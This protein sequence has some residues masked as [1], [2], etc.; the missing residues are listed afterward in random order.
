MR[1]VSATGAEPK[2]SKQELH[3][4]VFACTECY[5]DTIQIFGLGTNCEYRT[6]SQHDNLI[7]NRLCESGS[8]TGATLVAA[9]PK[10][11]QIGIISR[12]DTQYRVHRPTTLDQA[13]RGRLSVS[14]RR[15]RDSGILYRFRLR[16]I[17]AG[18]QDAVICVIGRRSI[19]M[20]EA[21]CSS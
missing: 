6:W 18:S 11:N 4:Y 10:N 2:S 12:R 17:C 15:P 9:H 13:A 14:S 20:S 7:G 19:T 16:A 1:A 5:D 21:R 8:H 3:S